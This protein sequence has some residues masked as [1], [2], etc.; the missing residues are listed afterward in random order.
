M[1]QDAL[2]KRGR[3]VLL[4]R[5][6]AARVEES[7]YRDEMWS[8]KASR[9]P[10]TN[11]KRQKTPPKNYRVPRSPPKTFTSRFRFS[12]TRNIAF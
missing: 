2:L 10:N 3:V 8:D 5:K 4:F 12:F 9:S 1:I 7:K 6:I 11:S